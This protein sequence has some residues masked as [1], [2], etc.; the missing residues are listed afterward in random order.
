MSK[1]P[2]TKASAS[3][4]QDEDEPEVVGAMY[5]D[6][7]GLLEKEGETLRW[8]NVYQM[9]K[10]KNF[11]IDV[12]DQDE[13]KIFKNIKKYGIFRVASYAVVFPCANSIT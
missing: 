1:A 8:G 13:L 9:F 3:S 2:N 5:D 10:K 12:E 11:S 7:S 6:T 4:Q